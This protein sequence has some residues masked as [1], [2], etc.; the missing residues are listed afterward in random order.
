MS[1][2]ITC[3]TGPP[4]ILT[5]FCKHTVKLSGQWMFGRVFS[6]ITS[7]GHILLM[8]R[9]M[10]IFTEISFESLSICWMRCHWN[11]VLTCSS[12]RTVILHTPPKTRLLLNE[13]FGRSVGSVF[14]VL[15]NGRPVH[16]ISHHLTFI[17]GVI[18]NNRYMQRDPLVLKIWKTE[19]YELA[20]Q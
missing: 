7:L 10:A 17:C 9:L 16:Q 19:L 8:A 3:I 2:A 11:H 4:K 12:S 20:V 5:G 18:L 15:T 1:T 6:G 14:T 13:K